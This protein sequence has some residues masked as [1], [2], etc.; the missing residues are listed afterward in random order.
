MKKLCVFVW[1]LFAVFSIQGKDSVKRILPAEFKELPTSIAKNLERRGCTIPQAYGVKRKHNVISGNFFRRGQ[2]DWAVLCSRK[3]VSSIL[4]FPN[5]LTKNVSEIA[6]SA[7]S[8]YLQDMEG[9]GTM[10]FSRLIEAVNAKY[11]YDHYKTYGG[12]KPPK[13]SYQGIN[14]AFIEKA[15]EVHYFHQGK[16]LKLQGA[17]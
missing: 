12:R 6:K 17:D 9:N 4:I 1:I 11:I 16:W 14:D 3:A 15:S 7:D 2:K 13:I 8:G 5:G 10:G